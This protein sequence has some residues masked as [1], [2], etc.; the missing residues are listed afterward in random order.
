MFGFQ[1]MNGMGMLEKKFKYLSIFGQTTCPNIIMNV[2]LQGH[3][4]QMATT[5][6][7]TR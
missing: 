3:K 5:K 2:H 6:A 4:H 7:T 1:Y